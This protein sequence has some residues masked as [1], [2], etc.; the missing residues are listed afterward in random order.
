M[1]A[2]EV[3]AYV[4]NDLIIKAEKQVEQNMKGKCVH[5]EYYRIVFASGYTYAVHF[6][7][8]LLAIFF[9]RKRPKCNEHNHYDTNSIQY[10]YDVR[11]D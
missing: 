2:K 8:S 1:K 11:I 6:V 5:E 10:L 4:V 3:T 7:E 9:K